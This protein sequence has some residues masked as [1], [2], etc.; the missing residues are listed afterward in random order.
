MSEGAERPIGVFDS[1]IGGLTVVRSLM[2]R[3]PGESILYFG[4]TARVPYGPKSRETV[5]R[6][7]IENVE[8]LAGYGVK[9][10]VVAC[11]TS[12]AFALPALRERF[13]IPLVG[14]VEPGARA[15]VAA[16]RRG[17]V[18]VIGT[19]G[20]VRSG[21]YQEALRRLRGDL[22][23]VARAC[24]L[25]VPIAEEGWTDHPAA[26]LVAEEYL[27]PFVD[28][29]VDTLI[30][31]CTHYPLLADVIGSVLPDV[32]LIDSAE[33]TAREIAALLSRR[34]LAREGGGKAI[35]RFL[36]SD[37]PERFLRVGRR[38]LGEGIDGVEVVSAGPV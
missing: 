5:T 8:M 7:S 26:R 21:A 25:F 30:L 31:G 22:E 19:H 16:T 18:G 4:D 11:N 6:F 27:A 9:A 34:D 14:V 32:V 33:E 29:G 17:S 35:H 36:V 3:L 12:T 37:L 15:G 10:V 20:T 28:D 2:E 13:T 1:G 23:V 38:F 24:P